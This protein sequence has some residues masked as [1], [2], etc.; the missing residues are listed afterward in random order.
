MGHA[1]H[2][3]S[4]IA[5]PVEPKYPTNLAVLVLMGLAL[6]GLSV[7]SIVRG[8]GVAE[9]VLGGLV[10]ALLVFTTWALGRDLAPDDN[11]AAFVALVPVAFAI[12]S[13]VSPLLLGP[14][15]A[16]GLA[17]VVN[18]TVGPPATTT[19]RV[20]MVVLVFLM[21]R[22]G[23]GLGVGAAAVLAFGLDAILPERHA[24]GWLWAGLAAVATVVGIVLHGRLDLSVVAPGPWTWA[25]IATAGLLALVIAT[26]P[27][28]RSVHDVRPHDPLRR[29]RVQGGMVVILVMLLP[30]LMGGDAAVQAW[31]V[32]WAA[33]AAVVLTRP[34]SLRRGTA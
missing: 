11:P 24:Q 2:R 7:V 4:S 34:L 3:V 21:A 8:A 29:D 12:A 31:I 26:Q 10:G 32:G 6:V 27:V 28:L 23:H 19:D 25:A 22:D 20:M 9:A 18:R 14:L 17:R 16:I 33:C 15:T 1:I 5:R 13:G 30:T